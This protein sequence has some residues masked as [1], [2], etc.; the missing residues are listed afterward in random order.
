MGPAAW[1]GAGPEG[2]SCRELLRRGALDQ[3]SPSRQPS[4]EDRAWI[5][6]CRFLALLPQA[7]QKLL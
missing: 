2:V 4:Q 3:A 7:S 5:Q 1:G 6:L